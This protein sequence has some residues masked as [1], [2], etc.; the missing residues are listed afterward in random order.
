MSAKL[1][2]YHATM[3]AGK[4]ASLLQ[5]ANNYKERGMGTLLLKPLVDNRFSES[6]IVS[7]TGISS[8]ADIISHDMDI[9]EY[10][11]YCQA[12]KDIHCVFVDESQF[13][14]KSNVR[15]L[16]KIAD[17][18]SVPVLCYGLRTDFR[19][20]LFEGSKYL[21]ALADEI[22]GLK[23]LCHCGKK[24]TMVAR[25]DD[26]GNPVT[27]GDQ[28]IIG[29]NDRYESLCRKHWYEFTGIK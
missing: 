15:Q 29:G 16:A 13:L 19:G 28:V 24:A 11:K 23:G 20:E 10:F 5:S 25:T 4:S 21:L 14:T 22:I 6:R 26:Y 9:F 7:R 18:Y 3:N 12:K 1:Y 2:F 27:D 17:I 8:E